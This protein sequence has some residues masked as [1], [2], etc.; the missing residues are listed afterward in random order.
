MAFHSN[1]FLERVSDPTTSDLDFVRLFSPKILEKLEENAFKGGV[2]I[3]RS[4]PGA[5]KTTLLRAFTPVALRGFWNSRRSQELTESYQKLVALGVLSSQDG[6]QFLGVLLSCAS[7]YADLPPG[8]DIKQEGLFRALF[9]CRIVLRTLRSLQS[10][11][12]LNLPDQL[13]SIHLTY[14]PEAADL[15]GIPRLTDAQRL[16]DWAEKH[17]QRVYAQLDALVGQAIPDIPSHPQF[18]GTIWLQAV[19]FHFAGSLV[20]PNRLLMADD[21]HKLR[22]KQRALLIDELTVQRPAIPVWLAERSIAL[23]DELLSQGARSGRDVSEYSLEEMWSGAKGTSQFTSFAQNILDRRM[24]TQDIVPSHSFSQCLRGTLEAGENRAE[25]ER[26]I[27]KFREDVK[28]HSESVRYSTWLALAEQHT[29]ELT[30]DALIE[31]YVTRILISRDEAKRQM[32]LDL[33]LPSEELSDRDSSQV[34]GAAE[35]FIHEEVGVPY[36]FGLERLCVMATSN[37]E[38]LLSLAAALYVGI[39]NKQVLR[40]PELN[41]SPGE[42]EKLLKQAAKE[43]LEFVPKNHT[44]GLRAKRLLDSIGT[45]CREKTFLPNAPYAPGVTGVRLSQ[46][47]LA[48]LSSSAPVREINS[49]LKRVLSEC[50][51]ENLLVAK[52]SAASTSREAGTIFYLNRTLCAHYDLPLQQGG[53]QDISIRDL[54]DWMERGLKPSRSSRLKID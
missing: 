9:D 35:I 3:F 32:T 47:E 46:Y 8:A 40:K 26:G 15:K 30:I 51:A 11:L 22:R 45:F 23:G 25:I 27:Q 7:G 38:E 21:L 19:R 49:P 42:Q 5:G 43:K 28:R 14:G 34:R 31:L 4:A 6:P 33:A 10:L 24:A 39:Q 20:A 52:P 44:E 13:S 36:Y 54:I 1:P 16:A 41:L 29:K 2:H 18:E 48:S 37:I 50:T 12:G 17:E 53:W